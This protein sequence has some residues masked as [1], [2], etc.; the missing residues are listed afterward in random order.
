LKKFI[1]QI[2]RLYATDEA[3]AQGFRKFYYLRQQEGW[4]E[5]IKLM[6]IIRGLM[7]TEMFGLRYTQLNAEEKDVQQ[8]VFSG[9]NELLE[10]LENPSPELE[11]A[12]FLAGNDDAVKQMMQ[13]RPRSVP[14]K[15]GRS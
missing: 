1:K 13:G 2:A 10:F 9:I 12:M 4:T 6:H 14:G 8:R 7:A 11:R 3:A 5:F 15:Q